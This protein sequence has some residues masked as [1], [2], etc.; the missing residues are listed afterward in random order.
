MRKIVIAIDGHSS[1]GKS[2]VAKRL[3]KAL[4]Y[5]YVDTGAM[6]R[7]VTLY[8]LE[9]GFITDDSNNFNALI[10]A[11][12][13]IEL[14]FVHNPESGQSEIYLNNKNVER[15]IRTLEVSRY[16]SKVAAIPEVRKKL[17]EQQQQMGAAKG[18]VM[19][20]RDIGT[21]VFPDAE[22]K[23]FMT[24][25]PEKRANRRFKELIAR[26]EQVTYEEV[27]KNVQERDLL[28]SSRSVSPLVQA[29][30]AIPFNNTDMGPE[31]QFRIIF[32]KAEEVIKN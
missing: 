9:C 19:D 24:A 28:D 1:T 17:V 11:L 27:L 8:A 7:A 32:E 25:T 15:E 22:L 3:A 4:G 21:V 12:E 29:K 10:K 6:Y 26:G 31:E 16:V 2:T 5:I 18:V 23:F 20:G 30:D 14:R 13:A